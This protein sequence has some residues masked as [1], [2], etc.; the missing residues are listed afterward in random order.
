MAGC[1]CVLCRAAKSNYETM[2]AKKRR[3]GG[4]NGVIPADEVRDH[5]NLLSEHGIG[6]RT[7]AE[8]TGVSETTLKRIRNGKRN[9]IRAMNARR[10][11]AIN[12]TDRVN[13]A[14]LVS[15]RP[16]WTQI[17]W[18]LSEGF[19]KGELA[20]RLGHKKRN[21]HIKRTDL[22]TAKTAM[23]VQKLYNQLREG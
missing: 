21:L 3:A 7:V 13:A 14:Q 12:P 22:V 20:L 2:R 10:I 17:K 4:W 1:K 16:V 18:L 8:L 9:G 23:R 19:T 5:L 6:R 15:S 11:L